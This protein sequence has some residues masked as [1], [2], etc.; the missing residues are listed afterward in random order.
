[1][2]KVSLIIM[3]STL[4]IAVHNPPCLTSQ[5]IFHKPEFKGKVTDAETTAPIEGAVVV[6]LYYKESIVDWGGPSNYLI[7]YKEVLTDKKGEFDLPAYTTIISPNAKEHY[8]EF[9]IYKPGY[10]N[11]PNNRMSPPLGI[12]S[13]TEEKYFLAEHFGKQG[14]IQVRIVGT[15]NYTK[16]KVTFGLVELPRLRTRKD[17]L[18]AI[19]GSPTDIRSKELPL[20]FKAMN[21]ENR[22]FGLGEIK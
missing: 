4:L 11:F 17:R 5:I 13:Q 1:M 14:E 12:S 22:R 7:H 21:E 9:I 8:T 20:L 10:G 19:P 3:L 6:A 15:W 16:Q 18:N 2:K